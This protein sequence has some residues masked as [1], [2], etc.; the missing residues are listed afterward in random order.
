LNFASTPLLLI[1]ALLVLLLIVA[2]S[3]GTEVA[4]LSVN[5]FRIRHRAQSGDRQAR[6]LE[7]LLQKPDEWLGANLVIL[8]AASVFASAIATILAQRTGERYAVPLAGVLLTLIVIVFCELAPKIY[9]AAKPEGVALHAAGVYRVLVG[10]ARPALWLTNKLAYGFLRVFGV[11]RETRSDQSLSAEELRTVVTEA[12]PVIPARHRQMLL[13]ILDLGRIT[14]NDIMVPRQEIAGIDL[15]ER[16]EDI[17]AQLRQ[18]PHTRLPVYEGEL[19]NLIGLLHMKRVA[20]ELVR[21]TFTRERLIEVARGREAYFVPEGTA[22]NVQLGHFQRNRRR[23][24]FVVN[25]YG[26]IEGLVTLEDILEEI[27]GEFTT[28]PATIT[29]KDVHLERPGVYIVNASATI[30]ALNRALG[31]QLPTGGPKTVNGLLLEHLE[32]IPDSGTMVRVGN[33]EFEVLQIADNA[34]RT[35]RVRAPLTE[36]AAVADAS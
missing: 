18:T 33:Y 31:W 15:S 14:V 23:F 10:V 22:L 20:Q 19:D 5:R 27:V 16:W 28:D 7:R 9:A 1:L 12:A 3:S 4:M 24:A 34:I 32:T 11:G 29:H 25:E 8:A 35:V 2:F 30:R 36:K 6:A 13:S 17:L 26:D 21:G